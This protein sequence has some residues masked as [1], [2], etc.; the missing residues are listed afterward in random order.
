M[1][2]H[3]HGCLTASLLSLQFPV[4]EL[5]EQHIP[6]EPATSHIA[7]ETGLNWTALTIIWAHGDYGCL[8]TS[9]GGFV[10][11]CCPAVLLL[12]LPGALLLICLE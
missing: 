5:G 7:A 12:R 10:H 2:T 6:V 8:F 11:A 3:T 9:K 1:I 4:T